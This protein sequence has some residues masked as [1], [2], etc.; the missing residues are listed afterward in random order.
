M[1]PPYRPLIDP[2]LRRKGIYLLPNLFTTSA[3]FAGFY[4]IVQAMSAQFEHAAVA[5]FVAMILDGLDGR[6][7]RMT[8]TQSPFG[9]E[10]DSL[11]DMVS[12]GVAPALVVYVWAL[13]AMG[14]LGWIA[15]FIFCVG[16]ALRLARFN[17]RLDVADKRYF[18]GLPSPSAAALVAGMVWVMDDYGY[19]GSEVHWF[20]WALTVVAGLTMVSNIRYYSFKEINMRKSI[21]FVALLLI[22]LGFALLSYKPPQVL[23]T[24]FVAYALS[25]YVMGAMELGKKRRNPKTK[26]GE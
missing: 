13:K 22:V 9:A 14:K 2:N 20:A 15:A 24:F 25:G 18:Q 5:I 3:L 1:Q 26:S 8:K 16:A 7:A 21:P 11:S 6:V 23:F 17:T 19:S 4:S 10:Y 12:F